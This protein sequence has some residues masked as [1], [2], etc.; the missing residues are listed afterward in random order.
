MAYQNYV[1]DNSAYLSKKSLFG[2][3]VICFPIPAQQQEWSYPGIIVT[4]GR[5]FSGK[6]DA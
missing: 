5:L 4:K 3:D 6:R 1:D 2:A